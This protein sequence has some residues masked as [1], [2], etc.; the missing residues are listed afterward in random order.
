MGQHVTPPISPILAAWQGCRLYLGI[1]AG[2][3]GPLRGRCAVPK[4][5]SLSLPKG[6]FGIGMGL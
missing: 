4:R 2:A 6:A 1:I 3:K 5:V